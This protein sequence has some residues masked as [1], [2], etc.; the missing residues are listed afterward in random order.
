M[1]YKF[2]GVPIHQFDLNEYSKKESSDRRRQNRN[3]RK[4]VPRNKRK[5]N[6]RRRK[7]QSSIRPTKRRK[8][9]INLSPNQI[10]YLNEFDAAKNGP[11]HQ[12]SWV[13]ENIAKF[14]Q[15][16]KEYQ[17]FQCK[18][19]KDRWYPDNEFCYFFVT[20]SFFCNIVIFL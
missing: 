2:Y 16:Q 17:L 19:C 18:Q 3:K 4:F 20:L 15:K 12:Q 1:G 11:L 6:K 9:N 7:S 14:H 8:T 10:N 13:K 5:S